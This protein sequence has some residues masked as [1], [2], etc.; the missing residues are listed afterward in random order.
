M[1]RILLVAAFLVVQWVAWATLPDPAWISGLYGEADFDDLTTALVATVAVLESEPAP[2]S[3]VIQ[4]V[5]ALVATADEGAR[6]SLAA[7]SSDTRSPPLS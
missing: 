2:T 6:D 3:R 4:N 1:R 7:P 5:V